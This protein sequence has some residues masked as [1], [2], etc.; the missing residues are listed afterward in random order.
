MNINT[1]PNLIKNT[2]NR[3]YETTTEII[4][5]INNTSSTNELLVTIPF[6]ILC[7]T[8]FIILFVISIYWCFR[9]VENEHNRGRREGIE[10]VERNPLRGIH[11]HLN[12]E[13]RLQ[14]IIIIHEDI[15]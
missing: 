2:E 5:K 15:D 9:A 1:L 11:Q 12:D 3:S 10:M 14:N 13:R 8:I 4:N 6:Q 7:S